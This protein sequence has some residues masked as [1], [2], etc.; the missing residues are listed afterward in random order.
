MDK[1]F[2]LALLLT[3]IVVILTPLL[4]QTGQRG[5]PIEVTQAPAVD[6]NTVAITPALTPP[7]V[8]ATPVDSAAAATDT[9][10]ATAAP[11]VADTVSV[12]TSLASYRFSTMGAAPVSVGMTHYRAL[13]GSTGPVELV[14]QGERLIGFQLVVPGDTID[15]RRAVFAVDSAALPGGGTQLDFTTTVADRGVSIR[16]AISDTSYVMN[17]SGSVS[18][19]GEGGA[20]WMMIDLPHGFASAEADSLEDQRHLSYAAKP[21]SGGTSGFSFGK[22]DPGERDVEE[23]PLSWVAAKNKYFILGLLVPDGDSSLAELNVVGGPRTGKTASR[24][25]GVAVQALRGG[26]FAFE[27]YA[28]PQEWKRMVSLGREFENSN[29]YGG[30]MQP[31]V[32]PFATI[33]MR[34]LLWMK[35]ASGLQYGWVLVIF[36]VAIRILLWPLNQRAMRTSLRMQRLQPELADVQKR[37][38][39]EPQKLQSE[40]MRIYKE[41]GMSP[42]SSLSGCLP[43]LLPM[44]ILFAL[45]F[46]FQNTI[47]F[48]GVPFLWLPD[49][50]LKDPYYIMP[51]LM[52]VSMFVTSLISMRNVP[53]NPQTKAMAYIMPVMMTLFLVNLASG[54]N[55]YYAVQNLATIPQQWILSN[56]RSKAAAAPKRS[57][58]T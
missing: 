5:A 29:P 4:F 44:P 1:R 26:S 32:Q 34:I 31:V 37:Y 19:A 9:A 55:L 40:M 18:G 22:L 20:A 56:E 41:H 25:S 45:F 11:A 8:S 35:Q 58:A 28:G 7:S 2:L 46:V 3:G 51:L 14:R 21:V 38:K 50:S 6:S 47:E 17:V 30:F 49:I 15:L 54:L 12:T 39:N 57:P 23:G 16:Y 48:R 42:F 24:A 33:M 43:M 52:G 27:M 36:G 10:A 53:P 13:D